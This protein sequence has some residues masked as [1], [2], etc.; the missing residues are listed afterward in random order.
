M[1]VESSFHRALAPVSYKVILKPGVSQCRKFESPRVHTR[2]NSR[3]RFLVH[4]L[5][6]EKRETVS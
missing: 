4:K 1:T 2:V 3:G 6:R 5:T